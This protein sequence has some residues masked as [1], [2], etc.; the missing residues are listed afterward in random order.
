MNHVLENSCQPYVVIFF[1]N[2]HRFLHSLNELW[3][4]VFQQIWQTSWLWI[5]VL[6]KIWKW[7]LIY[8]V[9]EDHIPDTNMQYGGPLRLK[10]KVK[11]TSFQTISK[12]YEFLIENIY[13]TEK[14]SFTNNL[15]KIAHQLFGVKL[16]YVSH[17]DQKIHNSPLEMHIDSTAAMHQQPQCYKWKWR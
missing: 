13:L 16:A 1:F 6:W 14:L 3:R 11:R 9:E 8:K 7:F 12:T 17:S 2:S 4:M 10:V 5:S 15:Q